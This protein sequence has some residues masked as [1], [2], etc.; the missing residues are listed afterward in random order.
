MRRK[1]AQADCPIHGH[2]ELVTPR[3]A[4]LLQLYS[5]VNEQNG[6]NS[7]VVYYCCQDYN[8]DFMPVYWQLKQIRE[9]FDKET[10]KIQEIQDVA[11]YG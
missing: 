4:A 9:I 7:A 8:L 3:N 5:V 2:P 10:Q 6:L 11:T 1:Q